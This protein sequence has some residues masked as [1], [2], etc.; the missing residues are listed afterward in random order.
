MF[1]VYVLIFGIIIGFIML[2]GVDTNKPKEF[3]MWA[4]KFFSW[5]F[6]N[7]V[8]WVYVCLGFPI[9]EPVEYLKISD[10]LPEYPKGD[11]SDAKCPIIIHNH[12]CSLEVLYFI[13]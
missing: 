7:C 9:K 8:K 6:M 10:Y 2:M 5:H 11:Q 4:K 13:N 3:P 1:F 12:H